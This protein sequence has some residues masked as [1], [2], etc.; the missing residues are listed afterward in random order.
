MAKKNFADLSEEEVGK[1]S[2]K[3][4]A[5]YDEWVAAGKP[6]VS[7]SPAPKGMGVYRDPKTNEVA[8][9]VLP[10]PEPST[11]KQKGE[12]YFIE[13]EQYTLDKVFVTSD[14]TVF[15]GTDKGKNAASNYAQA[16]GLSV[17][18]VSR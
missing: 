16:K 15:P 12:N 9:L 10:H 11:P 18:E 17:H 6:E 1:L 3:D 14:L 4:K 5:A 7:S 13:H 8:E 2:K